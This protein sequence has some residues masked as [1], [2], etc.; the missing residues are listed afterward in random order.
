MI[1]QMIT[2]DE[3][4]ILWKVQRIA[5]VKTH[6]FHEIKPK[7]EEYL[8]KKQDVSNDENTTA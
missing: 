3:P 5:A 1:D 7:L 8:K 6:H 2:M 4:V